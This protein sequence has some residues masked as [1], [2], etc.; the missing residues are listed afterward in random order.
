MLQDILYVLDMGGNLLSVSHFAC[1]RAKM[2]FKGKGC[3]L[4]NQCKECWDL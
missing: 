3:K 4:L 2:H 1:Y